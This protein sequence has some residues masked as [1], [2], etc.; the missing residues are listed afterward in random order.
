MADGIIKTSFTNSSLPLNVSIKPSAF[1]I[2]ANLHQMFENINGPNSGDF[3]FIYVP[4]FVL[5]V[6]KCLDYGYNI[7]IQFQIYGTNL[8]IGYLGKNSSYY[9]TIPESAPIGTTIDIFFPPTY[10]GSSWTEAITF[11]FRTIQTFNNDIRIVN[12][13]SL[14]VDRYLITFSP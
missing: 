1:S 8:S 12:N 2:P 11:T 3:L 14:A 7:P 10:I 5:T 13:T 4:S 9:E 6:E